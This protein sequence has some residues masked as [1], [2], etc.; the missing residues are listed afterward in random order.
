[1]TAASRL[2]RTRHPASAS[3]LRRSTAPGM[4]IL[5]VGCGPAQYRGV[6]RGDYVGVDITARAYAPELPRDP[7][8]LA[9]AHGLPFKDAAFDIVLFSAAFHLLVDPPRALSEA[10]RTLRRGGR[11]AIFDY[12]RRTLERLAG[13]Y[14]ST[15]QAEGVATLTCADWVRL[16]RAGGW[17]DPQVRLNTSS[18]RG[19][20]A[21]AIVPRPLWNAWVDRMERAILITGT[22]P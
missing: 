14:A 10:R 1:M 15:G 13:T 19:R 12:S 22:A 16:L 17:R 9:D 6:V 4:R 3:W 18:L 21:S 2:E 11:V 8:V 7:D 5:E 20:L